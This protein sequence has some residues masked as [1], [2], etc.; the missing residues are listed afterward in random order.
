M[1]VKFEFDWFRLL[2]LFEIYLGEEFQNEWGLWFFFQ[3]KRT[4][5]FCCSIPNCFL[6][7]FDLQLL[8][9]TILYD[10]YPVYSNFFLL[11][12]FSSE[13]NSGFE[14]QAECCFSSFW[15]SEIAIPSCRGE[16]FLP[17]SCC[18]SSFI[19]TT[20]HSIAIWFWWFSSSSPLQLHSLHGDIV[21]CGGWE[22]FL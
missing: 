5:I 21:L 11:Q 20:F 9:L 19:Q 15:S 17:T 22:P 12:S 3:L 13:R 16:K 6:Y 4:L 18:C 2:I 8:F 14:N 7:C 10:L 1:S